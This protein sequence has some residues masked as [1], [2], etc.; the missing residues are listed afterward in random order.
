MRMTRMIAV[1]AMLAP[2][3]AFA[4]PAPAPAAP[5]AAARYSTADTELG[6]LMDNPQTK[7]V[8]DKY[9]APMMNNPQIAQARGMTLKALQTYAGPMLTD[10][11][12]AK[13]DADLAKV[14]VAR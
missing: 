10:D 7:A 4:Q 6:T 3:A 13:I 2:A 8:L 12:L 14:P 11:V 1:L 5:A 9:I